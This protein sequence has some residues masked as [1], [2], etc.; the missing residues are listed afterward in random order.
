MKD[1]AALNGALRIL[2]ARADCLHVVGDSRA[3]AY[4]ADGKQNKIIQNASITLVIFLLNFLT[5]K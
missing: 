4:A 3:C 1:C 5:P 2:T